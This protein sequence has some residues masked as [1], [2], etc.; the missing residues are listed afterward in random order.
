[1]I[2]SCR[3]RIPWNALSFDFHPN[4]TSLFPFACIAKFDHNTLSLGH[5]Q[6]NIPP[7]GGYTIANV[8]K[9]MANPPCQTIVLRREHTQHRQ[10]RP[11]RGCCTFSWRASRSW[12]IWWRSFSVLCQP[13]DVVVSIPR[14]DCIWKNSQY[15]PAEYNSLFVETWIK[16]IKS[17][18]DAIHTSIW[19]LATSDFVWGLRWPS[20]NV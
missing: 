19:R 7:K 14:N 20:Q 4:R 17:Y 11:K 12:C 6:V 1:M 3:V 18:P 9:N 16:V 2:N 10:H 15:L 8:F 5:L 13:V